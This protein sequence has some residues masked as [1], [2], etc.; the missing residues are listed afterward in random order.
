MHASGVVLRQ[1]AVLPQTLALKAP[2]PNPTMPQVQSDL[3]AMNMDGTFTAEPGFGDPQF[4]WDFNFNFDPVLGGGSEI[5]SMPMDIE[6]WSTVCLL[7]PAC[8]NR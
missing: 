3:S 1:D 5:G 2:P 7:F 4:N 6:S 8:T